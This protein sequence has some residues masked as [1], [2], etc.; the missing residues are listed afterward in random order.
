MDT[1]ACKKYTLCT[2]QS[3]NNTIGIAMIELLTRFLIAEC[4]S[5]RTF[6][7]LIYLFVNVLEVHH[8]IC[9]MLQYHTEMYNAYTETAKCILE[10][11]YQCYISLVGCIEIYYAVTSLHYFWN[12]LHVH[13][14]IHYI[15]CT[16]LVLASLY[17]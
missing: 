2:Y 13:H 3:Q 16:C 14:V 15:L 7:I 12:L 1:P 10:S 11:Y 8:A 6:C 4:L 9:M 17:Q 5:T